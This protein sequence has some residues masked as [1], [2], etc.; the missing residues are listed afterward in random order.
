MWKGHPHPPKCWKIIPRNLCQFAISRLISPSIRCK[1][2]LQCLCMVILSFNHAE[3]KGQPK[4]LFFSWGPFHL[5]ISW[6][7]GRCGREQA[8]CAPWG[9]IRSHQTLT[10]KSKRSAQC[11]ERKGIAMRNHHS[12]SIQCENCHDAT[13]EKQTTQ[14]LFFW[15][16]ED[17]CN[18]HA[19]SPN[20]CLGSTLQST[21]KTPYKW[22][23]TLSWE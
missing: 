9:H 1:L 17:L 8:P 18:I 23:K 11:N 6:C 3:C 2:L 20:G 14:V 16:W 12:I 4:I 21:R 22:N 10:T 5:S 13:K 7:G 15:Q 19:T